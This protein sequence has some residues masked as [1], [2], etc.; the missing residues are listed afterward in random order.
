VVQKY[1]DHPKAAAA[2]LKQGMAFQA[3]GDGKSA[4]VVLQKLIESYPATEEAKRAKEKLAE[5]GK[6]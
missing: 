3:L 4:K 5:P 2:L 6:S 1:G